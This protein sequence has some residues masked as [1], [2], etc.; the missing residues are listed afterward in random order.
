MN[1]HRTAGPLAQTMREEFDRRFVLPRSLPGGRRIR[2]LAIR[3]QGEALALRIDQL[4]GLEPVPSLAALPGAPPEVLGLVAVGRRLVLLYSLAALLGDAAGSRRPGWLARTA[5]D[6]SLA[7]GFTEVDGYR[8]V[9]EEAIVPAASQ[10][11][12]SPYVREFFQDGPI[13]RA[14]LD[15]PAIL[16]RIAA[17]AIR[18]HD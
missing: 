15:L 10:G 18:G 13:T 14:I 5:R 8:E 11:P 17:P 2:L 12:R 9:L 4:S 6:P 16:D 1:E 3:V 7:L